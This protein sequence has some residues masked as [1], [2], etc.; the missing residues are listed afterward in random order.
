MSS[1]YIKK[2]GQGYPLLL[3][4]GWGFNHQ[5]WS[6][7]ASRLEHSYMIYR[8]DLPGFGKTPSMNWRAFKQKMLHVL[9]KQFAVVG[10]SMGGLIATRLTIEAPARVSHLMNVASSPRFVVTDNWP[11]I[12]LPNLDAFYA[13]LIEAPK[14]VLH[15]FIT[16]Q[17]PAS[18]M[19][20]ELPQHFNIEGLKN[21]LEILKTWDFRDALHT[22]TVPTAYLWGR[23]DSIIPYKILETMQAVYP[24][25]HYTCIRKA[26]HAP[27]LS[28]PEDFLNT[29]FTFIGSN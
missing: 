8:V 18:L 9:P 27:F 22:Q 13:A 1:V 26:G 20:L 11:G 25:F 3:L 24:Q 19:S 14:Q 12:Q 28:H 6:N 7:V 17:S 5:I 15:D 10:W 16:L 4:H 21:G 23:L 2:S 29:L